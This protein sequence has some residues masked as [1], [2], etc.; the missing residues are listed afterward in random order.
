MNTYFKNNDLAK[1]IL[2]NVHF[3]KTS[4]RHAVSGHFFD[5]K[6][7]SKFIE[8]LKE[9]YEHLKISHQNKLDIGE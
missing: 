8:L 3:S 4:L 2:I 6:D 9:A 7:I 5:K 1:T